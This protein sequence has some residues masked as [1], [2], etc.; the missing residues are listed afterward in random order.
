MKRYIVEDMEKL[1]S[2]VET[3]MKKGRVFISPLENCSSV[4]KTRENFFRLQRAA[5]MPVYLYLVQR[6]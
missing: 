2:L 6:L 3:R 4:S 1:I 5:S